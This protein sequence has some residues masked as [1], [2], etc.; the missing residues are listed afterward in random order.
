[1]LTHNGPVGSDA[2]EY[3]DYINI[4]KVKNGTTSFLPLD[5]RKDRPVRYVKDRETT[6]LTEEQMR[7]IYKKVKLGS[8]I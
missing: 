6:C 8:E 3:I 1:M 4:V 7:H 5:N 2:C